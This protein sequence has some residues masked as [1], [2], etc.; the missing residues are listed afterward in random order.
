MVDQINSK[1]IN[2][3]NSKLELLAN[4][5]I[6]KTNAFEMRISDYVDRIFI[7]DPNVLEREKKWQHFADGVDYCA[8]IYGFCVDHV[9]SET[10][11]LNGS[12]NRAK[13]APEGD[14]DPEGLSGD[15]DTLEEAK[16]KKA[17]KRP[18]ALTLETKPEL[19]DCAS[20]N[21]EMQFDNSFRQLSG[22]FDIGSSRG[23]LLSVL[24][25][26]EDID[27]PMDDF[28]TT[29]MVPEEPKMIKIDLPQIAGRPLAQ[30]SLNDF[31]M[32]VLEIDEQEMIESYFNESLQIPPEQI[33][34]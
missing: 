14:S 1:D 23:A 31:S 22:K 8:Q 24:E 18:G 11:Q 27:L 2:A 30:K 32:K 12:I 4:K 9:Y 25:T 15:E 3:F 29:K 28:E 7:D 5:K 33:M 19:L 34:D 21:Q 16:Q 13:V 17:K 6:N 10:F 20:F 26:T